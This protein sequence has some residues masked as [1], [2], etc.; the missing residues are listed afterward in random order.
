[1]TNGKTFML[2][3]ERNPDSGAAQSSVLRLVKSIVCLGP[4]TAKYIDNFLDSGIIDS[5]R[6]EHVSDDTLQIAFINSNT[7]R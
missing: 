6:V 1:M 5:I 4:F 2:L 7:L 3:R